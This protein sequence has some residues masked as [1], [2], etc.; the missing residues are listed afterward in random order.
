M[1]TSVYQ[2]NK[3]VNR[4]IEFKGL[5]AQYIWYLAAGVVCL[6]VLFSIM[7]ISGLPSLL[8]IVV[9]AV[10]GTI[11]V[12]KVYAISNKYGEFGMMKKM[13]ARGVPRVV[14]N[15]SREVFLLDEERSVNRKNQP[16]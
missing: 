16:G 6:L 15:K 2:I 14:R 9:I 1:A 11:L 5:K 3:G 8:C 4:S 7:Y 10:S 12:T 13:A